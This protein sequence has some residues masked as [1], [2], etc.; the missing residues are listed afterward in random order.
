M[1]FATSKFKFTARSSDHG[2]KTFAYTISDG[3][4]TA[5]NTVTVTVPPPRAVSISLAD[6][7]SRC[8]PTR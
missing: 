6:R 4:S 5:S 8:A 7:W 2:D 1:T 3:T